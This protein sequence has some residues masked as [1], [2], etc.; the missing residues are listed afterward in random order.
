MKRFREVVFSATVPEDRNVIWIFPVT[1]D[2]DN[3]LK[4]DN[5]P[6]EDFKEPIYKVM[7]WELGE[8]V[9]LFHGSLLYIKAQLLSL[10]GDVSEGKTVIQVL[11]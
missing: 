11:G 5:L 10:L 3:D 8:W 1:K 9:S 2:I 6:V 7:I 4:D